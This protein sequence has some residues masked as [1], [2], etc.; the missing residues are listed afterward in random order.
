MKFLGS[1]LCAALPNDAEWHISAHTLDQSANSADEAT[2]S[3]DDWREYVLENFCDPIGVEYAVRRLPAFS[4]ALGARL[5]QLSS[6]Y[7]LGA[8]PA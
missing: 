5:P 1:C 3:Q 6:C 7:A 4:P 8:S 2:A